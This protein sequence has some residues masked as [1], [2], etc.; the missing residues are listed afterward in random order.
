MPKSVGLDLG[1]GWIKAVEINQDLELLKIGKIKVPRNTNRDEKE[2]YISKIKELFQSI[3]LSRANVIINIR[4]SFIL[5]RTYLPPSSNKDDF[6]QWFV[7]SIESIIPGTPI[8]DVIYSYELFPSGRALIAF[9]KRKEIEKQLEMLKSCSIIPASIDASCL[10]LYDAFLPHPWMRKKKNFAILDIDAYSTGILIIKHGEA[11]ASNI[12]NYSG[13]ISKKGKER[14]KKLILYISINLEKL[15]E[16]YKQ[17]ENLKIQNIIIVGTYSTIPGLRKNLKTKY[18]Y[19]IGLGNPFL[20]HNI[21]LPKAYNKRQ[22]PVYAQ[23]L[24]LAVKGLSKKGIDLIPYEIKE[25]HK[26]SL[27]NKRT[28]KIA[29]LS[30]IFSGLISIAMIILLMSVSNSNKELSNQVTELKSKK[31]SLTYINGEQTLLAN[32]LLNLKQ[33]TKKMIPWSEI[34]YDLGKNVPPGIYFK[35]ITTESRLVTTGTKVE[36]KIRVV[37]EGNSQSQRIVLNYIKNLERKF[38]DIVIKNIKGEAKC[39]F[40]ISIGI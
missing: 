40:K 32:K 26:I 23:A 22:N 6:E 29:K 37:V 12:I 2:L 21:K 33:L 13:M 34:L 25:S 1:W 3:N 10:A 18:G 7:D 17:K 24:G 27:Y 16:F 9:A 31:E 8:E 38:K 11:F 14:D 20:Y 28:K 39:E 30:A 19:K 15:F 5:A 35:E 4:G 36:K